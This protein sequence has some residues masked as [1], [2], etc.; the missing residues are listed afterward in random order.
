MSVKYSQKGKKK[1]DGDYIQ[2][3]KRHRD[4]L[5]T[6]RE[7]GFQK[8]RRKT[9]GK[10]GIWRNSIWENPYLMKNIKPHIAESEPKAG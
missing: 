1:R 4:L 2:K 9:M 5:K 8:E 3:S 6:I 7:L 10:C